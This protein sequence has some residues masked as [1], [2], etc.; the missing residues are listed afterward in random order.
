MSSPKTATAL[1]N[2]PACSATSAR[3]TVPLSTWTGGRSSRSVRPGCTTRPRRALWRSAKARTQ[4]LC[5]GRG[6]SAA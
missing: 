3:T 2:G 5:S 4:S 1:R 6:A